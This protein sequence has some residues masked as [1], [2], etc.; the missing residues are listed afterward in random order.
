MTDALC[1]ALRD[2][3]RAGKQADIELRWLE[4]HEKEKAD[5]LRWMHDLKERA[6]LEGERE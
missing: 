3:V 5:M 6:R 1:R 4:E 2:I